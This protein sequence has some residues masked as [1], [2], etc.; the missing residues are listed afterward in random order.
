MPRPFYHFRGKALSIA[1]PWASAIA[2]AGKDVE[3]RTW[4]TH[5]RGPVA[6]H[7]SGSRKRLADMHVLR[8]LVRGGE[9]RP[10]V[11]W[12]NEGRLECGLEPEETPELSRIV[13]IAMLTDC[14]ETS[15]SMWHDSGYQAFLLEGVIP[16]EPVPMIGT[17][18]LWD[19]E[20]K[21]RP[22]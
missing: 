14:V 6:I 5:F 10:L 9:K 20:F 16:I 1:Q 3:N 13:A 17:L 7:A 18:G 2:F 19:C 11:E 12:I 4:R 21:Y 15:S 8:R 22:L